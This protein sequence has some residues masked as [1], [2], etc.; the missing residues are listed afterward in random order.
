M[1]LPWD[2]HCRTCRR[3]PWHIHG[4]AMIMPHVGA[5]GGPIALPWDCHC[6]ILYMSWR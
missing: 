2:C 3:L 1:A 5:M 6:R 4:I